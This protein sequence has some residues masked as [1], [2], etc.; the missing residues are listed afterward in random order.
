MY[1]KPTWV[2]FALVGIAMLFLCS[3]KPKDPSNPDGSAAGD[4]SGTSSVG[5][6]LPG[7]SDP[8]GSPWDPSNPDG[9]TTGDPSAPGSD[10]SSA[11]PGSAPINRA[12]YPLTASTRVCWSMISEIHT[13]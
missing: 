9:S 12:K 6:G 1:P 7:G 2:R 8:S 5:G 4:A 10:G 11:G 13:R 3:C